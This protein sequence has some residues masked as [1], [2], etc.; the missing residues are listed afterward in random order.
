MASLEAVMATG[1]VLP[2]AVLMMA[3][4]S[5]ACRMLYHVIGNLVGWP[6]L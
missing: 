1:L 6:Y 3:M 4:G 2:L 5:R